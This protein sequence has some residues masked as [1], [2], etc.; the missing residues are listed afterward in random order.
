[1]QEQSSPI[2]T[3]NIWRDPTS[4]M[5]RLHYAV[6]GVSQ[7]LPRISAGVEALL[8]AL[9]EAIEL[10]ANST[11]KDRDRVLRSTA[12]CIEFAGHATLR[13]PDDRPFDPRHP[14]AL[15]ALRLALDAGL[16]VAL[17]EEGGGAKTSAA[18]AALQAIARESLPKQR[19]IG[20]IA[21]RVGDRVRY[22]GE[23]ATGPFVVERIEPGK[24]VPEFEN[25][26]LRLAKSEQ[27]P[28]H[29]DVPLHRLERSAAS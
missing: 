26:H 23:P 12:V 16:R 14:I 22:R 3:A 18:E 7:L 20:E 5:T 21:P 15:K 9:N 28:I 13:S 11:A 8:Q 17:R 6:R 1:M 29:L 19:P 10:H 27:R 24:I 2:D 4:T 25:A